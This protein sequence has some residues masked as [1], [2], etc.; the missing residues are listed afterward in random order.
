MDDYL[1]KPIQPSALAEM[2]EKWLPKGGRRAFDETALVER[3]SGDREIAAKVVAGFLDDVPKQLAGLRESVGAADP[4]A[5]RMRA[6]RL[7]GAAAAV[8]CESLRQAAV[9]LEKAAATGDLA[10]MAGAVAEVESEFEATRAEIAET[11]L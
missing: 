5:T 1:A 9:S 8:G 7:K 2:L 11:G 6:H 4:A 3:L 10:R